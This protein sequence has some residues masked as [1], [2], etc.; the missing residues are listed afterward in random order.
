MKRLKLHAQLADIRAVFVPP[1]ETLLAP[2]NQVDTRQLQQQ[3]RG[4]VH[5][6]V[7]DNH[8]ATPVLEAALELARVRHSRLAAATETNQST[9]R[10]QINHAWHHERQ[11]TYALLKKRAV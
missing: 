1:L 3:V 10:C 6:V 5:T 4:D 9:M 7:I 2:V 8:I 11:Q